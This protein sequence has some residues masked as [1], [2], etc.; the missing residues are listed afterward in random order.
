ML[1]T[2]GMDSSPLPNMITRGMCGRSLLVSD[3]NT[4]VTPFENGLSNFTGLCV[5][6]HLAY[7]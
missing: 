6:E 7:L 5:V 1:R 4:L 3:L 2:K